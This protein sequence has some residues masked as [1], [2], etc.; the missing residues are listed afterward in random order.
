MTPARI[1]GAGSMRSFDRLALRIVAL[2]GVTVFTGAYLV[3][4]WS[5][6]LGLLAAGALLFAVALAGLRWDGAP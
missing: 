6:V 4:G 1:P 3:G 2:I 5:V